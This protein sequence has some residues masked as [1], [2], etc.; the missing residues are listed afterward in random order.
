MRRDRL[1]QPRGTPLPPRQPFRGIVE[2]R[3][4]AKHF[5]SQTAPGR[6]PCDSPSTNRYS[7]D[8]TI[9][10]CRRVWAGAVDLIEPCGFRADGPAAPA[11]RMDLPSTPRPTAKL[12]HAYLICGPD[13]QCGRLAADPKSGTSYTDFS[14]APAYTLSSAASPRRSVAAMTSS[15]QA[16]DPHETGPALPQRCRRGRDGFG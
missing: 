6:P 11:R 7:P 16:H 14:Y 4:F 5:P 2:I 10:G 15:S 12:V 1:L 9:R 3:P 13:P 8:G